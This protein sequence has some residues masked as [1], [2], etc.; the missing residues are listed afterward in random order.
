MAGSVCSSALRCASSSQ[1]YHFSANRGWRGC[2]YLKPS[3]VPAV[4]RHVCHGLCS[5]TNSFRLSARSVPYGISRGVSSRSLHVRDAAESGDGDRRTSVSTEEN[6]IETASENER[7][8]H[9]KG[10]LLHSP[11][12]NDGLADF[13]E[14]NKGNNNRS[15]LHNP[16]TN[17][18]VPDS[19]VESNGATGI[20]DDEASGENVEGARLRLE[21]SIGSAVVEAAEKVA[22]VAVEVVSETVEVAVQTVST[23]GEIVD[24][25]LE[26]E[27][28]LDQ[29]VALKTVAFWV[30]AAVA[31][32]TVVGFK[33]GTSKASEFFAGYLLEQSLSVDNLFVFVLIFNYFRVPYAYQSRVLTYGIAGAVVFRAT[34]IGLGIASLE[35]FEALNL[36]FAAILIFSSVKL[37]TESEEED[38]DL[39]NNFIVKMCRKVLPVTSS[40]DGN[41]FLTVTDGVTK[42]TPLLLTLVVVELS[43]IAFAVDS[44]PAVFGVTRDPFI[45]FSSNM[46]AILGLRS[47]YTIIS[48]SMAELQYLQPSVG[49]VLGFI[50]VKMVCEY[51]GFHVP[52]EA[53][54]G[55]VAAVLGVGVALSLKENPKED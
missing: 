54:L 28:V 45:V 38:D 40:Y 29:G 44:I 1:Q 55:V 34:M 50:G 33:E 52:T 6:K 24:P 14:E 26:E 22:E 27:P 2:A 43:D 17:D 46:F 21:E 15:L 49:V 35:R 47:L 11:E 25:P 9:H 5:N 19:R 8:A 3:A 16:Q 20:V 7:G 18:A 37:F 12:T 23:V 39:S 51:F 10:S 4:S 13:G 31:F 30:S 42:A 41:R 32:G 53:S 36:L 48:G